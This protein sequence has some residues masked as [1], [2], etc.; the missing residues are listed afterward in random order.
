VGGTSA[1]LGINRLQVVGSAARPPRIINVISKLE[2]TFPLPAKN[3]VMEPPPSTSLD[4][5]S[6]LPLTVLQPSNF[7]TMS[8]RRGNG[9]CQR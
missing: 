2:P 6:M 7:Q 9:P 1:E 8:S 5:N 3:R 4:Q